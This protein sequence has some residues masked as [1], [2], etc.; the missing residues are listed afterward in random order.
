[1]E[2]PTNKRSD[3]ENSDVNF[4]LYLNMLKNDTITWEVFFQIMKDMINF[5]DLTK[6][7]KLIFDLLEELKGSKSHEAQYMAK[8]KLERI[9]N[10]EQSN[11]LFKKENK[12]LKEKRDELIRKLAFKS[13]QG[14]CI[15]KQKIEQ[16]NKLEQSNESFRKENEKL[17]VKQDELQK[18]L[19]LKSCET[20]HTL[21]QHGAH[22]QT[23][24]G[25]NHAK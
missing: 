7:K 25:H 4:Q 13:R 23:S 20:Q 21:K 10:L 15:V 11:E 8:Q 14:Q 2:T 1:M 19:G 9:N 22:R 17:K 3:I 12:L 16:I 5:L 6:S 18:K 24:T